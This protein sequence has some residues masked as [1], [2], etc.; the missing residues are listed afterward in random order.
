MKRTLIALAAVLGLAACSGGDN[1]G[2]GSVGSN[3]GPVT[4]QSLAEKLG[5]SGFKA[6]DEPELFAAESASCDR[7][8]TTVYIE[9]FTQDDAQK[10][11]LSAA[12]QAG[13]AYV[14][15]DQWIVWTDARPPAEEIQK[16]LGGHVE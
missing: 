9:T 10:N 2:G 5:C 4:A 6:E 8:G 7:N 3:D 14:V 16:T 12:K 13:G 11:W 1:G 15:G